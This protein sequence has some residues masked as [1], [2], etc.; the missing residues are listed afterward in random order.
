M[1]DSSRSPGKWWEDHV[2][3]F[4]KRGSR[5]H[6]HN[7]SSSLGS[8]T[9]HRPAT[10]GST[11]AV[12]CS[13][14]GGAPTDPTSSSIQSSS[15]SAFVASTSISTAIPVSTSVQDQPLAEITPHDI[16]TL[17]VSPDPTE[18]ICQSP[19]SGPVHA[20]TSPSGKTLTR[21]TS[22]SPLPKPTS[23]SA[24]GATPTYEDNIMS[25][26][27]DIRTMAAS[28]SISEI[29][30]NETNKSPVFTKSTS[31]WEKA[32]HKLSTSKILSEKDK[33]LFV[34]HSTSAEINH[35]DYLEELLDATKASRDLCQKNRLVF[36]FGKKSIVVSEVTDKLV[37]WIEKFKAVGDTI[38]QFDPTH[39]ALPW[40]AVR[41]ILQIAVN[42]QESMSAVL[43]GLEHIGKLLVRCTVYE[44]LYL[45]PNPKTLNHQSLEDCFIDLYIVA[46]E[47]SSKFEAASRKDT[48]QYEPSGLYQKIP[49]DHG[50]AA[51]RMFSGLFNVDGKQA[52]LDSMKEHE[53]RLEKEIKTAEA[54]MR[55]D[56]RSSLKAILEDLEKPISKI[57][58]NVQALFDFS[59]EHQ[60]GEI[61]KWISSI[62]YKKHHENAK[63]GLL[64]N[65]GEWLFS[66][67][68][69]VAGG[70]TV[71]PAFF[72]CTASVHSKLI[73]CSCQVI[74][75]LLKSSQDGA[76]GWAGEIVV[77]F[78]C[79]RN[80]HER[81]DPTRIAQT[82]VKQLSLQFHGGLP[83]QIVEEYN[84]RSKDGFS[85][86]SFRF[87][88]CQALINSLL[89]L[90]RRTTIVI[91]AL[92]ESNPEERENLL[93]GLKT[94]INS[95]PRVVKIFVSSRDDQ[96][97]ALELRGVPNMYIRATDNQDDIERFITRE[98]ETN[99]KLLRTVISDDLKLKI[100]RTLVF[101]VS[102]SLDI[103]RTEISANNLAMNIGKFD[104][105]NYNKWSGQVELLL[106]SKHILGVVTGDLKKPKALAEN[107]SASERLAHAKLMEF[108][109]DKHGTA[110]STFLLTMEER[111][112]LEYMKVKDAKELWEQ[113]VV[114]YKWK[115]KRSKF[116]IRRELLQVKLEDCEDVTTYTLRIDRLVQ[117]WKLCVDTDEADTTEDDGKVPAVRKRKK[118]TVVPD[119]KHI[120]YL[121]YGI[122]NN[123]DWKIFLK[124][125]EDKDAE[126]TMWPSKVITK[127]L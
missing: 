70:R 106:E 39:A 1:S 67:Q 84:K 64:P 62:E 126:D 71:L 18:D 119:R 9:G 20:T 117:D 108:Y 107:A 113:L 81:R 56:E 116:R 7:R 8:I 66:N 94:L 122:P 92:D 33:S 112:Q 34:L 111:L 4:K 59:Q 105:A 40:A 30:L 48:A 72:G 86:G 38:V 120:F 15:T 85:A 73:L 52:I 100:K 11:S 83:N 3:R 50:L 80:E 12:Q 6:R 46:L 82:I 13:S 41:F 96:D 29:P 35:L 69:Y 88:E 21:A 55:Q 42:N 124:F 54:E 78:Y 74:D 24:Y 99:K 104:G 89:G 17:L 45:L 101:I 87:D 25:R 114:D 61:L 115:V 57:D 32:W 110:G 58:A 60:L 44:E 28:T 19:T 10:L 98:L 90:Y 118:A 97:I 36:E 49:A 51:V 43:I 53:S 65:T 93:E 14:T 95:S 123:D 121:L 79:N 77:Y 125:M 109:I 76:H 63:A 5:Q 16:D 37:S 68:K 102:R 22:H 103:R 75:T 27:D 23:T 47:F 91:D 127:M 26:A 31:L 2:E